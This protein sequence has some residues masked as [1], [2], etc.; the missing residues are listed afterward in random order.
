MH[1]GVGLGVADDL[2]APAVP[3][4]LRPTSYATFIKWPTLLA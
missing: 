2:F 1:A 3:A 4:D